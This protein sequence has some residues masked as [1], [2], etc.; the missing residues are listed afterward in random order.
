VINYFFIKS[1]FKI[2]CFKEKTCKIAQV[3][4]YIFYVHEGRVNYP[5]DFKCFANFL[6]IFNLVKWSFEAK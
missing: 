3:N 2:L 6:Y 5:I 4:I 1:L